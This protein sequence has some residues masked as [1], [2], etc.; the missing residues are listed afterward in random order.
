VWLHHRRRPADGCPEGGDPPTVL[1]GRAV[2]AAY[3]TPTAMC[4]AARR[5]FVA[6]SHPD[7]AWR[8]AC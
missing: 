5:H 6:A 7:V 3:F 2:T 8:S 4:G 1:R